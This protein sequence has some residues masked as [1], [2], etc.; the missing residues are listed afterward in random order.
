MAKLL[1]G[2]EMNTEAISI[3]FAPGVAGA[4]LWFLRWA[5]L[6]WEKNEQAKR[7]ADIKVA[8]RQV[9]AFDRIASRVDDHTAKDLEHHADVKESVVRSMAELDKSIARMDAKLDAWATP[10][11]VNEHPSGRWKRPKAGQ[12]T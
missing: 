3:Y 8:D 7:D 9:L 2:H 11:E 4:V 10:V 6:R 5:V 12:T 1:H